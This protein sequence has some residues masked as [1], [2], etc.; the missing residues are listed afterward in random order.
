MQRHCSFVFSVIIAAESQFTQK[1]D[2]GLFGEANAER[3]S[4]CAWQNEICREILLRPAYCDDVAQTA[5]K[6]DACIYWKIFWHGLLRGFQQGACNLTCWSINVRLWP[7]ADLSAGSRYVRFQIEGGRT[8]V[9]LGGL[10]PTTHRTAV[11]P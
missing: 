10:L 6:T 2:N 8:F 11:K 1:S 4:F 9:R 3:T 7:Q 5:V